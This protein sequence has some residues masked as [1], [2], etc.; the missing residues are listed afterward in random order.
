MA[1]AMFYKLGD[2]HIVIV[3]SMY[4]CVS[5]YAQRAYGD[6]P[7][8]G[9]GTLARHRSNIKPRAQIQQTTTLASAATP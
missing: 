2:L 9:R 1:R 8:R 6:S 7:R 4:V 5:Q 3:S